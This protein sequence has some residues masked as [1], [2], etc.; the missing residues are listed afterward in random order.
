M[1]MRDAAFTERL[2]AIGMRWQRDIRS[3]S[4]ET[5]DL[6]LP[7]VA[8][9]PREGIRVFRDLAYGSHP[10]QV[11]DVY[12]PAGA[13]RAG[14][15]VF[16]H[17]GAFVRGAKDIND[18]MYGNVLIW[19]A[20]QGY[21]G[22]NLE[23]RLA[24]E[25]PYPGGAVDIALACQWLAGHVAQYGGDSQRICLVGHSAGGTHV[26]TLIGDPALQQDFD[27]QNRHGVRCAVLISARLRAD[28]LPAN[29]N[30][31]GVAAYFGADSAT[32]DA[33][34]PV[35]HAAKVTMPVLVAN[36]EFENPLLDLY[37]LEYALAM[38]RARAVAPLHLALADHNHVSMVTH[39]N[40]EEQFLGEQI[41]AFFERA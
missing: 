3:A 6:Y 25:A 33:R 2:R 21:L 16:V 41:L 14:V 34:S 37:G 39:F 29:P 38:G 18:E 30:A 13:H 11:L 36:A 26:G 17:G 20:R 1:S 23:Y 9:G 22:I 12:Q 10:R 5:K 19:F 27:P 32:Y 15:I 4:D 31:G 40:T 7:L 28:D 35:S 8:R 24:P